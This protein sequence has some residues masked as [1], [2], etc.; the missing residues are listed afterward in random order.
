MPSNNVAD[1]QN[2]ASWLD[3]LPSHR[4]RVTFLLVCLQFVWAVCFL[5]ARQFTSYMLQYHIGSTCIRDRFVLFWMCFSFCSGG[6]SGTAL[7]VN[8]QA[9][10]C[11]T[12]EMWECVTQLYSGINK[13]VKNIL[14]GRSFISSLSQFMSCS[15]SALFVSVVRDFYPPKKKTCQWGWGGWELIPDQNKVWFQKIHSCWVKSHKR[16]FVFSPLY[17]PG[18]KIRC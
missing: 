14:P 8:V 4:T 18:L 10:R 16:R 3:R 11:S 2:T 1:D 12:L 15:I 17:L 9:P 13:T 5:S 6:S 7:S